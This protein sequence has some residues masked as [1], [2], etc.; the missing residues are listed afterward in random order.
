[1]VHPFSMAKLVEE[2]VA[3]ETR[4]EEEERSVERV[5][6]P[7]LPPTAGAPTARTAAPTALLPSNRDG[8][9]PE[10]VCRGL[11]I[12]PRGEVS[13]GLSRH[14]ALECGTPRVGVLDRARDA[15]AI[16][17]P[18]VERHSCSVRRDNLDAPGLADGA[19]LN[20]LREEIRRLRV[21]KAALLAKF[22]PGASDPSLFRAKEVRNLAAI[23]S[24]RDDDLEP[25]AERIAQVHVLRAAAL[26]NSVRGK[27]RRPG[28]HAPIL[29]QGPLQC[30]GAAH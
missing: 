9:A 25:A 3:G 13:L 15:E 5:L 27:R 30:N 28:I 10:P 17:G 18:F 21:E 16:T 22:S 26:T 8:A 29:E 6:H 19:E 24:E 20:L 14:P 2:H 1:M 7:G 4:R 12:D 23:E 11:Q